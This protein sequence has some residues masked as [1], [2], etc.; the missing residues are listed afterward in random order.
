MCLFSWK[1][2]NWETNCR[3]GNAQAHLDAIVILPRDFDFWG[4]EGDWV[5]H[6]GIQ[7]Y[8]SLAKYLSI[9]IENNSIQCGINYTL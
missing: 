4:L 7:K 6:N 9:Y 5:E 3:D 1:S 2:E 8:M